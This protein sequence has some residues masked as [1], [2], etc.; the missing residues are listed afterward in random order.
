MK[1]HIKKFALP[2][3]FLLS[4]MVF[5]FGH[6]VYAD[7]TE[8]ED[9]KNA[10][11]KFES[12]SVI[13]GTFGDDIQSR[14]QT[15]RFIDRNTSDSKHNY[16]PER[17]DIFCGSVEGITITSSNPFS[18][19]NTAP[20]KATVRLKYTAT[21][22]DP[23]AR[24]GICLDTPLKSEPP[25]TITVANPEKA[26]PNPGQ[27]QA[28]NNEDETS[29]CVV[30]GST[31][32]EWILCPIITASSKAADGVNELIEGQLFFNVNENLTNDVKRVWS[33]IRVLATSLL[34]LI[35]LFMIIS[36]AINAGFFDAY[37]VRKMLPRLVVAAILIQLSWDLTVW[38][39]SLANDAGN[40][41]KQILTLPFG[42][43]GALDLPSIL[44][45]LSVAWGVG[46]TIGT[47]ALLVVAP[48][49]AVAY[50]PA[51]VVAIFAVF[52]AT[53]VALATLLFRNVLI[54][55]ATILVPLA[56]LAWILP[57]TNRYWKM[58]QENFT[59]LLL[60]FPLIVVLIY[61]GRIF[62]WLVAGL[63]QA[64]F[65]DFMMV[66]VGFF[67]PYFMLPKAFSWGGTM[68]STAYRGINDNTLMRKGREKGMG[69]LKGWQERK[70]RQYAK[71]YNP[72]AHMIDLE[73]NKRGETR[74]LFGKVP[75]LFSG[76]L[77]RS[78]QAGRYMPTRRAQGMMIKGGNEWNSEEDAL[79]ELIAARGR[80]KATSSKRDIGAGKERSMDRL[81]QA[82]TGLNE[83]P[84]SIK[85]R[86]QAK[87]ALKDL[88]ATS[89]TYELHNLP[90]KVKTANGEI[91][92]FA[93]QTDAWRDL[94]A[95]S[96][97][98]YGKVAGS[99]PDWAPHRTPTGIPGYRGQ[100]TA[101]DELEDRQKMAAQGISQDEIDKKISGKK[102][103]MAFRASFDEKTTPW[104]KNPMWAASLKTTV[105]EL[106]GQSLARI[107]PSYYDRIGQMAE[108]GKEVEAQ[109]REARAAGRTA[110][111]DRLE[112]QAKA[113]LAPAQEFGA[114]M[115]RL[116]SDQG[117]RNQVAAILGGKDT[118]G[119]INNA[120]KHSGVKY[121]DEG[122]IIQEMLHTSRI[123]EA[124]EMRGGPLE[125]GET[126]ELNLRHAA[127][128]SPTAPGPSSTV[129]AQAPPAQ[130]GPAS[131]APPSVST[132]DMKKAF[133]EAIRENAEVFGARTRPPTP[134][135]PGWTIDPETGIARP[136][137][138]ED[139]Q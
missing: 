1:T 29:D 28:A 97:E 52:I 15:V 21:V 123:N 39:I 18:K 17:G 92:Q 132:D 60:L 84:R 41:I 47:L 65:L 107:H 30:K 56:L 6:V 105:E 91:E 95:G 122:K 72:D 25:R 114:F 101:S 22:D 87:N 81:A 46:T 58:W 104:H 85:W 69:E 9:I 23:R 2:S 19:E 82:L 75:Y 88:I 110:D 128:S 16:Q 133:G 93:W 86:R 5:A 99:S 49:L 98:L 11:Y 102:E 44:N 37:T 33:I 117:G 127:P 61:S 59:K 109:A 135:P 113:L 76:R 124:T 126:G 125:A 36:Q 90:V 94:L 115:E 13:I 20:I 139:R 68:L 7:A 35:M 64:A 118:E 80:E 73:K 74:K 116:L 111:A 131:Q 12:R 62:A 106:D 121:N 24:A 3:L 63:G 40:G 67:G 32:L 89:S 134:P 51:I 4:A 42:G 96:P 26:R 55:A 78:I 53:I 119:F 71:D 48:T 103:E 50:F 54:I 112:K 70:N 136:P 83:N 120:L 8:L 45:K 129:T 100:Y 108:S 79:E 10:T 14:D 27:E 34:V 43:P 138:R 137:Q 130:A 57:G 66:L 77:A 38:F 31:S